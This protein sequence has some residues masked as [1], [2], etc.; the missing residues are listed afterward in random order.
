MSTSQYQV[1]I[2]LVIFRRPDTTAVVFNEIRKQRPTHLFI[3]CDGPRETNA[4]D[5]E[6][7]AE[8]K[9]IVEQVDWP[10][11]VEKLYRTENLGCG[12][13]M[14]GAI[15]WFF[16]QVE[17]GV[18]LEDDCLPTNSFFRFCEEMLEYYKDEEKVLHISGGNFQDGIRRSEASY[19]FS[20]YQ[21]C[22]GWASWRR[23]W[24]LYDYN[25]PGYQEFKNGGGFRYVSDKQPVIKSWEK[26]LDQI[27]NGTV[28]SV[29]SYQWS[30]TI[31]KHKGLCVTPARNLVSNIGFGPEATHTTYVDF[32]ADRERFEL[33]WP[34]VHER[35]L[36]SNRKA[37]L[38]YDIFYKRYKPVTN[39][40]RIKAI[41]E[42]LHPKKNKYSV[43]FYQAIKPFMVKYL[44]WKG[45]EW[46]KQARRK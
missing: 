41:K 29:W 38:Y 23:A 40:E 20:I 12:R 27:H 32:L 22:W 21:L 7:I 15:T 3:A 25:L 13:N 18:I 37:D 33:D 39:Q 45:S 8:T 42:F 5:A 17:R 11:K 4:T 9:A 30:Y 24:K 34:L 26:A 43:R 19:Y 44:G 31:W 10:C 14:S 46:H 36:K 6:K 1:P 35:K 28:K 16:D 2:L